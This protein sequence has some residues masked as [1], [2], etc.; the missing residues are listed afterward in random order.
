MNMS[1]KAVFLSNR[2]YGKDLLDGKSQ[3]YVAQAIKK[4]IEEVDLEKDSNNILPRI[5]GV[6]GSWGSGKSNMLLQLQDKLKSNYYFFTY[7]AW[8]NQE[9]LQRR[10]ILEQLTEELIREEQLVNDTEITI[11]DTELDKEPTVKKCTWKRT[12]TGGQ[13]LFHGITKSVIINS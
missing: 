9:D 12:W 6:E 10:S 2:P 7:D 13:Y 5:I 11:L 4:H 3:D 8:G 1:S